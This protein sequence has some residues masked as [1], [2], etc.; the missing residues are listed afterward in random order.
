LHGDPPGLAAHLTILL[1][2]LVRAAP[3]IQPDFHPFAT[4][5]TAHLGLGIGSAI[6]EGEFFVETFVGPH[7]A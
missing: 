6:A 5:G 7:Y 4:V 2:L 3:R 1:I